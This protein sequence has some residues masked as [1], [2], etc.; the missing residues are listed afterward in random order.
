M[1][2]YKNLYKFFA[3]FFFGLDSVVR[4]FTT[5]FM[6]NNFFFGNRALLR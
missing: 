2:T 5:H 1:K 4:E 3:E 6:F